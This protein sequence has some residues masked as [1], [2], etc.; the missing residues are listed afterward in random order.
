VIKSTD[1]T[2]NNKC[3]SEVD[4]TSDSRFI[5]EWDALWQRWSAVVMEVGD[6]D[7]RYSV[8]DR[9]WEPPYFDGLEFSADIEKKRHIFLLSLLM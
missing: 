6:E 5:E 4:A 8:Q 2:G 3:E 7:G 9:H 1:T